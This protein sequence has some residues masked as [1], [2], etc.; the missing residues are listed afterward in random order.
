ML[1]KLSR[2]NLIIV[3]VKREEIERRL[4]DRGL[5]VTQQR[6]AVMEFLLST[7]HHPTADEVGSA[8]NRRVPTASR[9]SVYNVLHSLQ[10]A[11]LIEEL[12]LDNAVARYDANLEGH[13]HFLC[14]SCRGLEDVPTSL[15]AAAVPRYEVDGHRVESLTIILKGVCRSCALPQSG[16]APSAPAARSRFGKQ[17]SP[18]S[19]PR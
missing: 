9:A 15:F 1:R 2:L 16:P 8:V 5:R 12:I 7:P 3:T 19:E 10:G 11:G 17:P 4:R 18:V 14:R 6:L 13:S